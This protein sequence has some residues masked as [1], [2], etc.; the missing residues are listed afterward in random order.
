M[1]DVRGTDQLS[2]LDASGSN[3][4]DWVRT[5]VH[6]YHGLTIKYIVAGN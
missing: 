5:N 3:T 2:Y 6:A 4:S 1:I